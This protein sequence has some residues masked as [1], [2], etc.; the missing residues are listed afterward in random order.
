MNILV[1]GGGGREHALAWRL[2]QDSCRPKLFCAPGNAGTAA[3]CTNLPLAAEDLD[4]LVAW[5]R[6]NRP[7]LT[8]VGPEIALCLGIT[9]ALEAEGLRVFGPCRAAARM[10]GS[11][12]FAKEV[13]RA[14]GVPT[15]RS[16]SFRSSAAAR[17][18]LD[19]F[20]LPV[21]IKA[22]GLAAGKGVIIAQTRQEAEAA[23]VSMLEEAVFG[24]AGAEVLIEEFLEGEEASILALVDGEHAV[25]LPSS[26]D[27]KRVS[28]GDQGPNTG[29]MGAYSP[30]PVVTPEL[31]P[32]IRDTVILPVVRELKRRG[33][34]YKGVLYAGLM[35]GPQGIRVLEF[36]ARFGDPETQAVLPRLGGDLIPALEACINGTLSDSLLTV[37][38]EAAATVILASGGYPGAYRKGLPVT[39]LDQAAALDDV[40]LFHAGTALRDGQIVTAGGRVLA[41]TALGTGLRAAVGRAYEAVGKIHFEGLHFR[42]D[43]AHRALDRE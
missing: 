21:V 43:I 4:G 14:A 23:L 26:Q 33:I 7:D 42:T 19:D 27:H 36:N 15:A 16:A 3:F 17:A 9:D 10:E 25:L 29:G 28:D 12:C 18:A 6:E 30:A 13:M 41:V 38:P 8:V 24:K 11:K 39:G 2:A 1:I 35:I 37:R 34:V 32:V 31:L 20:A 22:D 40:L 5:S